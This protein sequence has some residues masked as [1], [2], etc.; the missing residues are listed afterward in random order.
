[1]R[2]GIFG[3]KV[4]EKWIREIRNLISRLESAKIDIV[5]YEPYYKDY[6]RVLPD[7]KAFPVFHSPAE[8]KPSLDFMFSI[9]GDGTMLEAVSLVRESAIPIL[10]INTG[11]L[12]FLS[13]V[14]V[15]GIDMA[16]DNI[17]NKNYNIDSRSLISISS[18]L[19]IFGKENFALNDITINKNEASSMILV[20]AYLNEEFLNSYWADGLIISTPTGSTAYSLSCG[21]PIL[22]PDSKDFV[23]TPIAPH[24]L[25][26][27]PMVIN[28]ESI[29]RFKTEGRNSTFMLGVDSRSMKLEMGTELEIRKADFEI[30]LVKFIE[31]SFLKTLRD[32]LM[33][34]ADKR[35]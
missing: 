22:A 24:N 13:C 10:G 19:G 16:I 2:I 34:G 18:G 11:R 29:L 26:V 7:T 15:E 28:S 9:G 1:M 8:I 4:N 3:R 32:K 20:H 6:I 35:I 21:G 25:N 30:K 14:S 27:R 17:L 33:W 31:Q 12:G 23:I 5:F